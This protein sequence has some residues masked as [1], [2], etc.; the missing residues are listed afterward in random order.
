MV[1]N[2]R[3]VFLLRRRAGGG[4][5]VY[6]NS[7]NRDWNCWFNLSHI[8]TRDSAFRYDPAFARPC[9]ARDWN[10]KLQGHGLV[11]KGGDASY[12]MYIFACPVQP[13]LGMRPGTLL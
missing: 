1:S 2:F 6:K 9:R 3:D 11:F 4:L 5:A 7:C 13:Q 8:C 12:G 10:G